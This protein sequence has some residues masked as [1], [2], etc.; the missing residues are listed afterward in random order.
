[1]NDE[2]YRKAMAEPITKVFEL[3]VVDECVS[4]SL[5]MARAA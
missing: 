3:S 1:M 5:Y 4:M 2:H